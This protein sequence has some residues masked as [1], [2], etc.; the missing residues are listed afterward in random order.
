MHGQIGSTCFG[1]PSD[2][3]DQNDTHVFTQGL[4]DPLTRGDLYA[5]VSYDLSPN[6]EVY[7]T[8]NYGISRTENI[9]AQGN[10]SKSGETIRCDNAY[11]L[12][13]GLFNSAAACA[14]A[15]NGNAIGSRRRRRISATMASVR[16]G[17]TS[18]PTS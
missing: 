6:A 1:T 2:P 17:A 9:P 8:M 15:V 5:R 14:S 10:S 18:P 12:Q 16:T 11:L 4:Y 13:S 7:A 3:G